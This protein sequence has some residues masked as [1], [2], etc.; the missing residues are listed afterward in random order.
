MKYN[1]LLIINKPSQ[2][3]TTAVIEYN[4]HEAAEAAVALLGRELADN[5]TYSLRYFITPKGE[6]DLD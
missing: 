2:S 5:S 3:V 6:D 1:L 4:T